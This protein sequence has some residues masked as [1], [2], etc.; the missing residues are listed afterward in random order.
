MQNSKIITELITEIQKIAPEVQELKLDGP[1]REQVDLDSM[2]FLRLISG[3][4]EHFKIK[5]PEKDY[6]KLET[7]TSFENYIL[8]SSSK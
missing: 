3:V 7:L 1:I 4:S 2:D 5:I 6:V 8:K